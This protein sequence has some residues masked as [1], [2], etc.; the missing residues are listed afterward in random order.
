MEA[1]QVNIAIKKI[2]EIE[3]FINEEIVDKKPEFINEVNIKFDLTPIMNSEE[4]TVELILTVIFSMGLTDE[5]FM[6]IKTSNIF[7][8]PELEQFNNNDNNRFNIPENILVVLFSLSV[9]HT[10]ALLSKSALGTKYAELYIPIIN[11][12]ELLKQ[13]LSNSINPND[14]K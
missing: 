10:R 6:K 8:I 9:S 13:L 11:P 2:K 3:F 5:A 7:H 4:S 12:S 1:K 14:V